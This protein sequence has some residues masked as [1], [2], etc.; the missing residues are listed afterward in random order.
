MAIRPKGA[1][2]AGREERQIDE[3]AEN[4]RLAELV[5]TAVDDWRDGR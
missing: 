5:E 1:L 2:P 4:D 3:D